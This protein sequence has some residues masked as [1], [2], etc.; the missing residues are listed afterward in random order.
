[1][2]FNDFLDPISQPFFR[3]E[4]ACPCRMTVDGRVVPATARDGASAAPPPAA[5]FILSGRG[6]LIPFPAWYLKDLQSISIL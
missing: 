2:Q 3:G 5:A 6:F 1:M 4:S